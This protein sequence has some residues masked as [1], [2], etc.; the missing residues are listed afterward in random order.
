MSARLVRAGLGA[1]FLAVASTPGSVHAD[2]V[3][4]AFLAGNSEAKAANWPAAARHYEEARALLGQPSSL[5]SYDL[6][7]AYA[8][9]GELG[10]ATFHL[11]QALDFRG[12]P[13]TEIA[14]AA[15]SNLAVVR[16]RAELAAATT[17]AIIDAPETW[18][19]LV[20]ETLRG[21]GVAWLSMLS[22]FA[23]LAVFVRGRLGA[24]AR[25]AGLRRAL[26]W[27]TGSL[28]LVLA[29]LHIL[30]LRA[31][32]TTPPAVVLSNRAEAREGPGN[33]RAVEFAIQGGS[34]VRIVD[35]T[36]GW[37]LVR[38][39]GGIE[40]WVPDAEVAEFEGPSARK[41]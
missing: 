4:D 35:R 21:P 13:T 1:L 40:G 29:T 15:R 30:S 16:R 34:E 28:W 36:P 23:A 5:L 27:T 9:A 41:P 24:S 18:W 17:N 2:A 26:V 37:A 10:R 7:T 14:E 6:G 11:R 31:D 22:G 20:V 33:H 39:T 12:N 25:T 38:M 8:N 32:R 19:D 3:D